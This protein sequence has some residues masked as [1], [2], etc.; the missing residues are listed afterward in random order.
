MNLDYNE[1]FIKISNS[2]NF[3]VLNTFGNLKR[4]QKEED[5][6]EID[7]HKLGM[8]KEFI[9]ILIKFL[10]IFYLKHFTILKN[11]KL[12]YLADLEYHKKFIKKDKEK[13]KKT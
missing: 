10:N 6:L 5:F 4:N 3:I 12:M 13:L 1:Q 7:I 2:I 8:T 9:L 11:Y